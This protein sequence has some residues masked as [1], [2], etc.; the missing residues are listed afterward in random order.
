MNREIKSLPMVALRGMTIM[1]EM[2]VHF[3]VSRERGFHGSIFLNCNIS[4]SLGTE[5]FCKCHQLVNLLTRHCSLSFCVDTTD[6]SSVLN[7]PFEHNKF[8]VFHSLCHIHQFH[9]ETGIRFVRTVAVHRF[10]PCHSLDR[11]LY[12]HIQNFLEQFCKETLV[13]FDHV[14]YIHKGKLHIDLGKLRLSVCT[15]I[16]VTETFCDLDIA[17]TSGTH[18]KLFVKLW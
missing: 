10:L 13:D 1:P 7:R 9:T 12:I 11:K 5:I 3:D 17:V 16:L 8:T 14:I 6:C 18:Q 15:K 2:V 4:K